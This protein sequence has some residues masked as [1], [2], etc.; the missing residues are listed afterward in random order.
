MLRRLA[1][2]YVQVTQLTTWVRNGWG[3]GTHDL[4]NTTLKQPIHTL[5]ELVISVLQFCLH[6]IQQEERILGI[7]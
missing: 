2:A 3:L 6:A 1:H 4:D 5:S 7:W